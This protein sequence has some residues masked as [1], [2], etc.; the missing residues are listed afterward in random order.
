MTIFINFE[1]VPEPTEEPAERGMDQMNESP[2]PLGR[3]AGTA[4]FAPT[5]A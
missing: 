2:E 4:A 3:R 5:T 1:E